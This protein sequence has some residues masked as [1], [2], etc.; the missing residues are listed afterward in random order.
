M[1]VA[2]VGSTGVLGRRVVAGLTSQGHDVV[3]LARSEDASARLGPGAR[4]MVGDPWDDAFLRVAFRDAD[5]VMMLATA[6]P[7]VS[8]ALRLRAWRVNDRVRSRLAPRVAAIAA[9]CRV[10]VLVQE[11][12]MFVYGDAG[13]AEITEDAQL[14]PAP[15]A[16]ACLVAEGAAAR[17]LRDGPAGTRAVALRF[18]LFAGPDSDTALAALQLA[19][20]G[21]AFLVG[22]LAGY[23]TNVHIDDAASAAVHALDVPPGVYNVGAEPVTK[24]QL[25]EDLALAVGRPAIRPVPPLGRRV[26]PRM[27]PVLDSLG[28]SIRLDSGKLRATGWQPRYADDAT[29]WRQVAA[30]SRAR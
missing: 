21:A 23:T 4:V 5:A 10:G 18:A 28:R 2:V 25:A 20:R 30:D 11:S 6:I 13:V 3:A 14:R 12:M 8:Q 29:I 9:E 7:P 1:V 24:H 26:L 15:Q 16:A 19:R 27:V 17:F 22:D